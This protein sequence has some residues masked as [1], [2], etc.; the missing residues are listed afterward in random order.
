MMAAR[1]GEIMANNSQYAVR[2]I[3]VVLFAAIISVG[4]F[5]S[6]PLPGGVPVTLQNMLAILAAM[7]LGGVDG[8]L[9]SAL[10]LA[11]GLIGLPVFSGGRGGIAVITGPTGGFLVG[12][13]L[14][15]LVAGFIAGRPSAGRMVQSARAQVL[16]LA[17]ASLAGFAVILICGTLRFM[18]MTGKSLQT[19]LAVCVVPFL[20][21]DVIKAVLCVFAAA[22]LRRTTLTL[23]AA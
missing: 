11:A 14:G 17:I 19:T 20:L 1:R 16:R 22:K 5:I 9:A 23:A 2:S 15:A 3:F 18:F 12:Y 8:F 10:F 21:G 6:I 7:T 13:A 4:C